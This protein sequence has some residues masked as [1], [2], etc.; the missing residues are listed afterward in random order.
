MKSIYIKRLMLGLAVG[1]V[2]AFGVGDFASAQDRSDRGQRRIER[3]EQQNE[4]KSQRPPQD[5]NDQEQRRRQG[6]EQRRQAETQRQNNERQAQE[7]QRRQAEKQQ[8]QAERQRQEQE[9]R[10]QEQQR[11][12]EAEQRRASQ[13][14]QYD[15]QQRRQGEEQRRNA[16]LQRRQNEQQRQGEWQRRQGEEHQAFRIKPLPTL[17]IGAVG[18]LIV[19]MTSVG[20]GSLI[21]VALLLVY[22]MLSSK[23][24]VGT[25]LVQAIPLVLAAALGHVLWGQFELGLTGSLLLGSVPGVIV[26]AQIS[27]RAPD[28]IVRPLLVLVLVLSALKLLDAPNEALAGVLV[29]A[30]T[31]VVTWSIRRRRTIDRAES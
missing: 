17:L 24:L 11:Q 27:S 20:S 21:I 1:A 5:N 29:L 19:G 18:G 14:R 8:L 6:E 10:G 16:E 4:E 31:G 2:S 25:D 28:R 12:N 23:E 30:G 3:R 26:G 15:E 13:Q 7:Q 22:P 9:R